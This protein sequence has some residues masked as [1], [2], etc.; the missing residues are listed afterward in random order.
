ML[1]NTFL[2]FT[3]SLLQ[4]ILFNK[5]LTKAIIFFLNAYSRLEKYTGDIYRII[6]MFTRQLKK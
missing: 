3:Q 4:P 1:Q 2:N 6:R 5:N